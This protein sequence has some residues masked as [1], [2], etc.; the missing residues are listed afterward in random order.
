MPVS[1]RSGPAQQV[2]S[3]CE[4]GAEAM[5]PVKTGPREMVSCP[6]RSARGR[7]QWWIRRRK[8]RRGVDRLFDALT[9]KSTAMGHGSID[10]SSTRSKGHGGRWTAATM[11]GR[12]RGF[13][14]HAIVSGESR[15]PGLKIGRSPAST[16][17]GSSSLRP[18]MRQYVR[19][20]SRFRSVGLRVELLARPANSPNSKMLTCQLPGPRSQAAGVRGLN[21]HADWL[22]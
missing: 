10:L 6:R 7:S 4:N 12:V 16:G 18:T 5:Q 20:G 19:F 2:S 21:F 15:D 1:R 11:N 17:N 9:T 13:N 22:E 14:S 3:I 8:S